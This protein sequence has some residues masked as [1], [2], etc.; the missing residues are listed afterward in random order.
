[1]RFTPDKPMKIGTRR[2]PLAMA[3]AQETVD[4][5]ANAT[6]ADR[7]CFKLVPMSTKGDEITDRPLSDIGGKG[8]FT[9]E[10]EGALKS[11]SLDIAVHSMKDMPV[12]LPKGLCIDCFLP[13]EDPRDAFVSL[14]YQSI[15]DLPKGATVGSSSLR[16]RAQLLARRPELQVVEFRGNV[17]KRLRKL[18]EGVADATFLACAGLNRLGISDHMTPIEMDEILPAIAQG[19]IGIERRENDADVA[20]LLEKINCKAAAVQMAAERAFLAGLDGSCQTP[21]AGH[22]VLNGNEITLTGE[23]IRPDG[24]ETIASTL[25]GATADAAKIGAELA[26]TLRKRMGE[27]FF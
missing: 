16:R 5:L 14:N 13:R 2:S 19:V 11:G 3:Q 8:L 20:A 17:Q 23:V 1:M 6:G 10:I 18:G 12:L 9:E 27:G 24:S 15:A 22:A 21:I 25:T 4:R 26:K 7:D